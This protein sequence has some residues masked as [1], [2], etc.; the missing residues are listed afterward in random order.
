MMFNDR[1]RETAIRLEVKVD[2]ALAR[3][4][5]LESKQATHE[6]ICEV[7]HK[8][9]EQ[10]V[11]RKTEEEAHSVLELDK[12][13]EESRAHRNRIETSVW[14]S[15]AALQWRLIGAMFV[16]LIAACGAVVTLSHLGVI[17]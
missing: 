11:L 3:I 2:Q 6:G 5:T 4:G 12:F 9:F 15:N 1:D 8:Q 14:A 16:L 7:R 10:Y 13:M 17:K